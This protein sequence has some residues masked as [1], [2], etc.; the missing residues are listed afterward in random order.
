[1][2]GRDSDSRAVAT[3]RA[4]E[5]SAGK[6]LVTG[7]VYVGVVIVV[8]AATI[9][10]SLASLP[11]T[12]HWLFL[13]A[14]T[15]FSGLFSI[16][17]PSLAT[18][19][20]PSETFVFAAALLFGPGA[21]TVVVA[22]DGLQCA[23]RARSRELHRA[24]FNIAEPALSV[25]ISAQCFFA[26]TAVEPLYGREVAVGSM[27]G[28]M[29]A[30]I[31]TFF[32]L[33]SSLIAFAVAFET[34]ISPVRF[35]RLNAPHLAL[36]YFA[37][38][39]LV[40]SIVQQAATLE[41]AAI[42]V[43]IPLLVMSYFSSRT[44]IARVEETNRHLIEMNQ[45]HWS[46]IETLAMAIDAKDQVT[47][48]HIRRVQQ[49]AVALARA[50]GVKDELQ[51][52]ALEAAGL[53]HD[54]GKLAVPEHILNKPGR[55]TPAEFEQMKTHATVGAD[56]LSRIQFP[57]PVTP[58]VRHH[59]EQWNGTGYPDGLRGDQ[60]PLG[61]RILSVVDCFDALTSDRP[62]RRKLSDKEAIEYLKS[63]RGK[64][65]DPQIVD[66]FAEV[67]QT[68]PNE[69]VDGIP[70]ASLITTPAGSVGTA[71]ALPPP[72]ERASHPSAAAITTLDNLAE[73]TSLD[74]VGGTVIRALGLAGDLICVIY[75]YDRNTDSLVTAYVSNNDYARIMELRIPVGERLSGWV[76]ANRRT[77]ANSDPA[78]DLCE[79]IA[80]VEPRLRNAL[81]TALI[82]DGTIAGVLSLYSPDSVGFSDEQIRR[83]EEL[84]PTV[85]E[86]FVRL[87]GELREG[88]IG[89]RSP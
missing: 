43:I 76:A 70:E 2:R 75:R 35:L 85:A 50:L 88:A 21:A 8:G 87:G 81:S 89:S 33:N 16:R 83:V 74:A 68:L 22:V 26:L 32:A 41:F 66:T 17:I 23:W 84:A 44:S 54:L 40:L 47:H 39:C 34:R 11:T 27:I 57:Y 10:W 38:A 60:I 30:M 1:M 45:L 67:H 55:L 63:E 14:L 77:V 31:T 20:S 65:Y 56:I 25:W 5:P 53:L 19:F 12:Y 3:V 24:L 6:V 58:I 64:R 13:L 82:A 28:P 62:Y 15:L 71:S 52:K 48:S 79:E 42:G 72:G 78:L 69:H 80:R 49:Q 37:S 18:R 59:H 73:P 46:T 29:L 9:V 86:I 4:P 7:Q 51:I 61:A 36:N